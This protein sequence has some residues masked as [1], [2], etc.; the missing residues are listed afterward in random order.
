MTNC[1]VLS[2]CVRWWICMY[3]CMPFS[4]TPRHKKRTD[5]LY[6]DNVK[7]VLLSIQLHAAVETLAYVCQNTTEASTRAH[8]HTFT[9]THCDYHV[10]G[11]LDV[12]NERWSIYVWE[13][14]GLWGT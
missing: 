4:R 13:M 6:S 2:N 11:A 12:S 5:F 8:K 10:N 7:G 14:D 1:I 9:S 3:I